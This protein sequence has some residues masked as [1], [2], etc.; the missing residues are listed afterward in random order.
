MPRRTKT[1]MLNCFCVNSHRPQLIAK[2]ALAA[3]L[4]H[5]LKWLNAIPR[6]PS[7]EYMTHL[8]LIVRSN[9]NG[10]LNYV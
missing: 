6:P 5:V 3:R 1:D 8:I 4:T 10:L 7:T 9:L 2:T